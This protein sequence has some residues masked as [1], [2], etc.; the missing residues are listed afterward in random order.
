MKKRVFFID[1]GQDLEWMD[2]DTDSGKIQNVNSACS[3]SLANCY[4]GNYVA[5]D[6]IAVGLQLDYLDLNNGGKRCRT[7]YMISEIDDQ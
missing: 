6:T 7:R 3:P 4:I 2:I 5:I 1:E